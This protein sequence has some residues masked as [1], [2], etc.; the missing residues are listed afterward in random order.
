MQKGLASS[1]RQSGTVFSSGRLLRVEILPRWLLRRGGASVVAAMVAAQ[2]KEI[3]M[4]KTKSK[5]KT[6]SRASD[7]KTKTRHR[8]TP[9]NVQGTTP[10]AR[11]K[12]GGSSTPPVRAAPDCTP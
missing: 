5:R 10:Q 8:V 6:A 2:P 4:P 3:P 7:S 9:T 11:S 12:A 1:R